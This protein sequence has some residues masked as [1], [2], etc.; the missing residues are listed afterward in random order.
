MPLFV[1][2]YSSKDLVFAGKVSASFTPDARRELFVAT[3][4]R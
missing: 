4:I 2:V 3:T 1:A